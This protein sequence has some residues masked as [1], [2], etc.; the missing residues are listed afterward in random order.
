M[1][2]SHYSTTEQ[3]RRIMHLTGDA[4]CGTEVITCIHRFSFDHNLQ[5]EAII[6]SD[7]AHLRLNFFEFSYKFQ[8]R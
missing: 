6:F 5:W 7:E 4:F 3:I 2:T 8:E 1:H